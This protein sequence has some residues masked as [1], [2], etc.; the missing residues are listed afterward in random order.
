MID[1]SLLKGSTTLLILQ[2]LKKED[3]YGYQMIDEL[4]AQS[5]KVFEL[6]AG[7]LYPLLHALQQKDMIET[8][9][10]EVSGRTRKYYHL[11]E[12]GGKL[13]QEKK[14]EWALYASSMSKVLGG[15]SFAKA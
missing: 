15:L 10:K 9:D 8:Y 2:L 11:T 7:T 14:E 5:N 4:R 1:N 3:M 13:L 6:K 12:K